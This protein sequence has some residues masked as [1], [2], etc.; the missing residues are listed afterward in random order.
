MR[1]ILIPL[2]IYA[3]PRGWCFHTSYRHRKLQS[4]FPG[5]TP[6]SAAARL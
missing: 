4:E 3:P 6:D 2:L 1:N 5:A